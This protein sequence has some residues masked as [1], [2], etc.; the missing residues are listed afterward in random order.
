MATGV[1]AGSI[2]LELRIPRD[3]SPPAGDVVGR[4]RQGS[5]PHGVAEGAAA[6]FPTDGGNVPSSFTSLWQTTIRGGA[7][8]LRGVPAGRYR[9]EVAAGGARPYQRD[10]DVFADRVTDVGTLDPGMG[11]TLV[12]EPAWSDGVAR[13]ASIC[14]EPASGW[15]NRMKWV[16]P[17]TGVLEGRGFEPGAWRCH[18]VTVGS[19]E[20]WIAEEDRPVVLTREHGSERLAVTFVPAAGLEIRVR[21]E[22]LPKLGSLAT[23]ESAAFARDARLKTCARSNRGLAD[24]T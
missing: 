5:S 15:Y 12:V 4:V 17:G 9:L 22:R 19:R 10:V 3:D 21:G 23:R 16:F 6:L 20:L 7:F 11:L 13:S 2:G 14:F 18:A 24:S 1:A 8:A